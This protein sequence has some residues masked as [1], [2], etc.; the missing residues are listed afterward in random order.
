M[1]LNI[2]PTNSTEAQPHV[3]LTLHDADLNWLYDQISQLPNFPCPGLIIPKTAVW[4]KGIPKCIYQIKNKRLIKICGNNMSK[5]LI[6]RN[7]IGDKIKKEEKP[8]TPLKSQP[9]IKKQ[10]DVSKISGYTAVLRVIPTNSGN[11]S[12]TDVELITEKSLL[13]ILIKWPTEK[14]KKI[15]YMHK[16]MVPTGLNPL[17]ILVNYPNNF[18]KIRPVDPQNDIKNRTNKCME[19][20]KNICESIRINT[21]NIEIMQI[22]AEFYTTQTEFMINNV[23]GITYRL[24]QI[25]NIVKHT[26]A[27]SYEDA[28]RQCLL[29]RLEEHNSQENTAGKSTE[30][31]I[32]QIYSIMG[33][34]L[35]QAKEITGLNSVKVPDPPNEK[36]NALFKKVRPNCKYLFSELLNPDYDPREKFDSKMKEEYEG[37][38]I[39]DIKKC[40]L[41][42][43]KMDT[44]KKIELPKNLYAP[45]VKESI[46]IIHDIIPPTCKTYHEF[47][48]SIIKLRAATSRSS[49]YR[50]VILIEN[51][52]TKSNSNKNSIFVT[53]S[54]SNLIRDVFL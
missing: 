52:K 12:G 33:N 36:S 1:S 6:Q 53:K 51:P 8:F 17:L 20:L 28:S 26:Y 2:N 54:N 13:E 3:T 48:D 46:R 41:K 21:G 15:K 23:W 34:Q 4:E 39:K 7:F 43:K 45:L 18:I 25:E 14:L 10:I 42:E 19:F 11:A 29:K 16:Y 5:R 38:N 44:S 27:I 31:F 50:S 40:I 9:W 49:R 37:L 32:G 30:I 47:N 22:R 24:A 35:E